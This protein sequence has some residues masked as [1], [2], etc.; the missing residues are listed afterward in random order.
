[1]LAN[2]YM[3]DERLGVKRINRQGLKMEVVEYNNT[4]HIVVQFEDGKKVSTEWRSFENNTV[5]NPNF[6]SPKE[7]HIR[8]DRI[9]EIKTNHQGCTMEIIK[10]NHANNITVQFDN[11]PFNT[12]KTSYKSFKEGNIDNPL[13]PSVYGIGVIGNECPCMNGNEKLKE[14]RIWVGILERCVKGANTEK[15]ASYEDC[16]VSEEFLYYPNFYRWIISQENYEV[17]KNTPGFAVDKDILCKGNRVYAPDKCCLVPNRINN[18][19]NPNKSRRGKYLI[20]TYKDD[21]GQYVAQCW[22]GLLQKNIRLGKFNTEMEAFNAYK[23]YKEKLIKETAELEYK[24]GIISKKC[25]DALYKFEVE[26][27]D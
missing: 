19:I 23:K 5:V 10:Y 4:H 21:Y 13:H 14:Y 17:W 16:E 12:V 8:T 9:G 1:M 26:T 15:N 22:N 2:H 18:L 20:G 3:K 7:S 6:K 25:R 24:K 11:N 27:T